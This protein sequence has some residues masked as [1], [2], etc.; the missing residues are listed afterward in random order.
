VTSLLTCPVAD[1]VQTY[2]KGLAIVHREI[3]DSVDLVSAALDTLNKADAG[4]HHP[5]HVLAPIFRRNVAPNLE[6]RLRR[7]GLAASTAQFDG[8]RLSFLVRNRAEIIAKVRKRKVDWALIAVEDWPPTLLPGDRPGDVAVLWDL[9]GD[10]LRGVSLARVDPKTWDGVLAIFEEAP[11][12][13]PAA[14]KASSAPLGSSNNDDDLKDAVK[15]NNDKD[16]TEGII[17]A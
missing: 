9:E 10:H 11:L 15:L 16:G 13:P 7:T 3:L 14:P 4:G 8:L 5:G 12:P 6:S 2:A 17:S 1:I